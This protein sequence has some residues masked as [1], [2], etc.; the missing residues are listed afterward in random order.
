MS[1]ATALFSLSPIAANAQSCS[2]ADSVL[3]PLLNDMKALAVS[4]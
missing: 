1:A 4:T 2:P 3:I